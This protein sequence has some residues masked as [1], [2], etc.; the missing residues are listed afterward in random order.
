MQTSLTL[1]V[2][3]ALP[4]IEAPK[5]EALPIEKKE[6][7][8]DKAPEAPQGVMPLLLPVFATAFLWDVSRC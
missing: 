4:A 8:K 7:V 5:I 1:A 2:K 6:P 3:K